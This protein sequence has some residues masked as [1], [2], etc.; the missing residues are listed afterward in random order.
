M[1]APTLKVIK[2][3]QTLNST[4]YDYKMLCAN[5]NRYSNEYAHARYCKYCNPYLNCTHNIHTTYCK[6]CNPTFPTCTTH[7]EH[8]HKTPTEHNKSNQ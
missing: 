5:P 1:Y 6:T 4:I 3:A 8:D 2:Y 7:P